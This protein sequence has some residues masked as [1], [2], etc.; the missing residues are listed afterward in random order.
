M[1]DYGETKRD[2]K[3]SM[4]IHIT[5]LIKKT[6]VKSNPEDIFTVLIIKPKAFFTS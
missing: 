3:K 5:R 1:S 2:Q 6:L 4:N